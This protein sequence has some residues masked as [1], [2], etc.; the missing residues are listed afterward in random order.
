MLELGC[1]SGVFTEDLRRRFTDLVSVD[2][3]ADLLAVAR[4]RM[5][6][7][8]FLEM[9]AHRLAFPDASFEAVV[10][11]SILHHL[12]WERALREVF[13]VLKP[14]GHIRF[15]EPNLLNPQIFLQKNIPIIKRWVGDTP[16][17]YA[18]TAAHIRRVLG[19]VGFAE[20]DAHAIEFLHPSTPQRWIPVVLKLERW[21]K[22]PLRGH[23]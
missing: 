17:E 20:I 2:L 11:V 4:V 3:S 5:P 16:D 12:D 14:G 22:L 21:R 19:R 23:T 13:R 1:G 18:F 15:S 8:R 7:A 9:D 10:G 6:Q